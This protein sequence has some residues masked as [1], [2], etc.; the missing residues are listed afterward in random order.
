MILIIGG[1]NQGKLDYA[2]NK[3]DLSVEKI[4]NGEEL[5]GCSN[6]NIKCI[7]NYHLAVKNLLENGA[8]PIAYTKSLIRKYPQAVIIM[9]EIG[10][11]IIP[12]EK[13]DRI[14][15]EQ[16][17]RVGC[18]LAENADIVTRIVCGIAINIKD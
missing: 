1:A 12:I 13:K 17:G 16:T 2:V 14:W 7:N 6:P 9:N 18:L 5:Y 10:S 4:V 8:D 3:Y 11:G 15:R